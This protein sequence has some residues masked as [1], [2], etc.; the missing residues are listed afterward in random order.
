MLM[1]KLLMVFFAACSKEGIDY[2]NE[3]TA[4]FVNTVA[5]D[6]ADSA[7]TCVTYNIHLGFSPDQDPWNPNTTGAGMNQVKALAAFMKKADADIIALQEV[8]RNRYNASVKDFIQALAAEMGMNYA[9]GSHGYND[10]YDI[11][12]VYGEW[13]TAIMTKFAITR[14]DLVQVEY[15]DKWTKRSILDATLETGQGG[16]LHAISL[17]WLP[18]DQAILNTAAH[19]RKLHE[20]VICMGDFNYTGAID[21]FTAIGMADADSLYEKQWIDRIFYSTAHFRCYETGMFRDSANMLSDHDPTY[22][23]FTFKRNRK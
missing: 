11:Y 10:P 3:R 12:P 14:I 4:W 9:F 13:G 1:G 19:L 8:P 7:M 16:F 15:Q 5:A 22:G 21:D 20:P 2:E 17:H 23:K 18:S 6:T